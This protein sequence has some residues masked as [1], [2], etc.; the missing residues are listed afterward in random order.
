MSEN[1]KSMSLYYYGC[2]KT[3]DHGWG[4]VYRCVQMVLSTFP[5][6]VSE[7]PSIPDMAQ[8]MKKDITDPVLKNRWVEPH[9]TVPVFERY[10]LTL[11][12]YW[13]C[14]YEKIAPPVYTEIETLADLPTPSIIDDGSYAYVITNHIG[15]AVYEARD[16]HKEGAPTF[17]IDLSARGMWMIG[18][19]RVEKKNPTIFTRLGHYMQSLFR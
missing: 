13:Y 5:D 10:G 3:D 19:P 8:L 2:D 4:C 18:H 12:L 7:I 1:S 17:K 15:G 14:T 6:H 11:D 9:D 16:P